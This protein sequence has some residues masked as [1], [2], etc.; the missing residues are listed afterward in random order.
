M[1][2]SMK[3]RGARVNNLKD[4]NLDIPLGK[5]IGIS[6]PSGSGKSSLAFHTIHAEAKRRYLNSY[7]EY[8]KFFAERPSP[9]D[10]DHISPVLPTFSLT[11]NNPVKGGRINI[12]D[13]LMVSEKWQSLFFW[14]L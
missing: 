5:I 4:I 12:G 13:I 1:H 8:L 6:G 10:V 2:S 7:P 9:V 14:D 3:I 11:Q